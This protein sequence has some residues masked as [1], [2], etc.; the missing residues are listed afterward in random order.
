MPIAFVV[1]RYG[2]EVSGGA[3]L[4]CWQVVEHL[5]PEFEIEVLTT[6][7]QDYVTRENTYPPGPNTVNGIPVSLAYYPHA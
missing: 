3:E 2:L 6:C 5:V 1:Q 4:H 7:A